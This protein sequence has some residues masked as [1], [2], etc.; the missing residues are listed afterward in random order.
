[1]V[2]LRLLAI[3]RNVAF[4][5]Y[6]LAAGLHPIVVLH[7]V[8]LP[9]NLLRFCQ[10]LRSSVTLSRAHLVAAPVVAVKGMPR[11]RRTRASAFFCRQA[12]ASITSCLQRRRFAVAQV[13]QPRDPPSGI[14]QMSV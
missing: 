12:A 7:T 5:A 3:A 14:R 8:M 1:M 2:N 13:G 6:P 4:I 9:L 10:M 11:C